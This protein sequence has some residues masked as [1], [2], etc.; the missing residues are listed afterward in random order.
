MLQFQFYIKIDLFLNRERERE[1]DTENER[2]RESKTNS[3]QP[4]QKLYAYFMSIHVFT[5][6]EGAITINQRYIGILRNFVYLNII[7][8]MEYSNGLT[9]YLHTF[10]KLLKGAYV[11]MKFNFSYICIINHLKCA[12][13][14][15]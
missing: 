8:Y 3:P 9:V 1:R 14:V 5:N 4:T 12:F 11:S 15:S 6:N 7:V 13:R 2:E 10:H